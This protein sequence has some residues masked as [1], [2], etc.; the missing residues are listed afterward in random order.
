[1]PGIII[2]VNAVILMLSVGSGLAGFTREGFEKGPDA[3][4]T[5]RGAD[6]RLNGI[7]TGKKTPSLTVDDALAVGGL[8]S[9]GLQAPLQ[10][11]KRSV[12][13]P[14]RK[15]RKVPPITSSR[16]GKRRPMCSSSETT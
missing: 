3:N 12:P 2:G 10:V 7:E 14:T 4:V 1:M 15:P 8:T 13:Y 6:Q 9:A 11:R 16:N 5:V